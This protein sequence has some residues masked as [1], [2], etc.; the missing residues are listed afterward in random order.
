MKTTT[1]KLLLMAI[2]VIMMACNGQQN[3]QKDNSSDNKGTM[4]DNKGT[5]GDNNANNKD[6][7]NKSAVLVDNGTKAADNDQ[8]RDQNFIKE[9]A[10]GGLMEVEMGKYAQQHAKNARVKNFGAMMVRDHTK[11]NEE[12]KSIAARKNI[13]MPTTMEDKNSNMMS[14]IQKKSGIDFDKEYIKEM[15][16]DHEKDIDK[17]KK[18]AEKGVDP[19]LKAFAS[20]TLPILL[21]H[22][23]SAK[24]I[25]DAIK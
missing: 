3:R 10:S 21:M 7:I 24:K 16:D 1:F 20:K 17:F 12:L 2:P 18:H 6:S 15:V 23:D 5:M 22:Q 13:S 4:S 25:H 19:D 11:A 8:N 14:D 9:A